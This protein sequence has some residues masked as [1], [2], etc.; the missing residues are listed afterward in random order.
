MV[1]RCL[2]IWV[3]GGI[4]A[5]AIGALAY[6]LIFDALLGATIHSRLLVAGQ[7]AYPIL[8]LVVLTMLWV[9]CIPSRF[10]VGPAFYWLIAGVAVLLATDVA[11]VREAADG[12]DS[13]GTLL[14]IGWAAAIVPIVTASRFDATLARRAPF[15]A[16]VSTS[17]WVARCCSRSACCWKGRATATRS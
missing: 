5:L 7:L 2:S 1:A 8:D 9:I 15:A 16:G 13:P 6:D 4:V 14:G 12:V 10:R 3:D 11:N 17:L